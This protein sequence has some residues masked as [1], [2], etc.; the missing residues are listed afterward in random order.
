MRKER[1]KFFVLIGVASSATYF[2]SIL[3][4]K[5]VGDNITV[6]SA[7]EEA[8]GLENM[9][10]STAE[11]NARNL[12]GLYDNTHRESNNKHDEELVDIEN[13]EI[14]NDIYVTN[15]ENWDNESKVEQNKKY[16]ADDIASTYGITID[17]SSNEEGTIFFESPVTGVVHKINMNSLLDAYE[18]APELGDLD[19]KKAYREISVLWEF[20]V[21]QKG[22]H[23]NIASAIIGNCACEGKF[24]Q[25]QGSDTYI[26]NIDDAEYYLKTSRK[27]IGFGIVQWTNSERRERLY[28]YYK[29]A[30]EYVYNIE[31]LRILAELTCL[32]E[33][34]N[35]Y[36]LFGSYQQEIS[37]EDACGRI[38]TKYERYAKCYEDWEVLSN[39]VC[40][41]KNE[42]GSGAKRLEYAYEVYRLNK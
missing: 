33:E 16:S 20:L 24:G 13:Y 34:L 1:I 28:E 39:G 22:V 14:N 27:N 5:P 9:I 3:L 18:C 8:Y 17:Y 25:M 29:A 15:S 4:T 32:Y 23:K 2:I 41:L 21:E 7:V 38:S 35:E 30:N 40:K 6:G 31:S 11:T 42:N 26:K 19:T 37:I 36:G 12:A 10:E